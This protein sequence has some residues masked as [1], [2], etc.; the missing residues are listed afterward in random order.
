MAFSKFLTKTGPDFQE[1]LWHEIRYTE[2]NTMQ[3]IEFISV[4]INSEFASEKQSM[5]D[6]LST[7]LLVI[8]YDE[9][10]KFHWDEKYLTAYEERIMNLYK[11]EAILEQKLA[12]I[13]RRSS[14]NPTRDASRMTE[15]YQV[16]GYTRNLIII[17]RKKTKKRTQFLI[18]RHKLQA[19]EYNRLTL[20]GNSLSTHRTCL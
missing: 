4:I 15:C 3:K 12:R 6:V 8:T 17:G 18:P 1:D 20:K 19:L 10:N 13:R 16:Y 14:V 5:V 9:L 7:I 2:V 11:E